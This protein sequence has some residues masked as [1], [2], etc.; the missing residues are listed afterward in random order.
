MKRFFL[1][2]ALLCAASTICI[3]QADAPKSKWAIEPSLTFPIE[4]IYMVNMAYNICN[5]SEILFGFAFQN[6]ENKNEKPI[7]KAH[8]YTLTAGYRYYI[9]KGLN[10]EIML[11][12]AYNNFLSYVDNKWYNGFESW[13]EYRIGYKI[14]WNINTAGFYLNIQPGIGHGLYLQHLWPDLN[15]KTMLKESIMFIPQI[16]FGIKL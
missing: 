16:A 6:W 13:I 11:F 10:A 9:W 2:S 1:I 5:K 7:G 3:S 14:E 8:A 15:K 12:P 4:R